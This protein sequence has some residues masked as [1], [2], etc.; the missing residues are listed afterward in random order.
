VL[1]EAPPAMPQQRRDSLDDG[2]RED[3]GRHVP[4]G[5][6]DQQ[7]TAQGRLYGEA[8]RVENGTQGRPGAP[9]RCALPASVARTS[10]SRRRHPLRGAAAVSRGR[11]PGER[12]PPIVLPRRQ[13]REH[14]PPADHRGRW[15]SLDS[16]RSAS[17]AI[18]SQAARH[19][20][21]ATSRLRRSGVG[22]RYPCGRL[23]GRRSMR[24]EADSWR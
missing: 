7:G 9:R 23:R 24:V 1:H 18:G 16:M 14:E 15:W 12:A 11:L 5:A 22:W 10:R 8:D 21:R 6:R 2:T 4:R 13:C 17:P 3:T 20:F 19:I